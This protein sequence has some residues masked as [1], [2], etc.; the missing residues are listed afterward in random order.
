LYWLSSFEAVFRLPGVPTGGVSDPKQLRDVVG[1]ERSA[2]TTWPTI[3]ML[4]AWTPWDAT[5]SAISVTAERSA[6]LPSERL[7]NAGTA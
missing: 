2:G 6:D 4:A 7:T 3:V 5:S 1:I